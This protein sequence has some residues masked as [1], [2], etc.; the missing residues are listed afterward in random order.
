MGSDR[1]GCPYPFLLS[2]GLLEVPPQALTPPK[3]D[4]DRWEGKVNAIYGPSDQEKQ[5]ECATCVAI[6]F[7]FVIF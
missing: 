3:L 2:R 7:G 1:M 6:T 4:L 5:F